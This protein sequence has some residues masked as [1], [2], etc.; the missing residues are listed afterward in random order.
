MVG[1]GKVGFGSVVEYSGATKI[2]QNISM[3]YC[4]PVL[5]CVKKFRIRPVLSLVT[6]VLIRD[7]EQIWIKWNKS[8]QSENHNFLTKM[9]YYSFLPIP[10]HTFWYSL[11]IESLLIKE[12]AYQYTLLS[13]PPPPQKKKVRYGTYN[14]KAAP[15]PYL[16]NCRT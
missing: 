6:L 10:S 8:S 16:A 12:I 5:S 15:L 13:P 1:S 9:C 2:F 3:A 4:V 11:K 7:F 14:F